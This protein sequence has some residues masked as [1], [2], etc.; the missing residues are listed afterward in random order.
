[1]VVGRLASRQTLQPEPR[2]EKRHEDAVVLVL[3]RVADELVAQP[4]MTGE[5]EDPLAMS[6][7]Q[8]RTPDE[9]EDEDRDDH[10]PEQKGCSATRGIKLNFCTFWR[11]LGA[12]TRAR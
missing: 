9:G 12:G 4:A 5:E 3:A 6:Q 8:H 7:Y 11:E 1:L 2:R 10:D